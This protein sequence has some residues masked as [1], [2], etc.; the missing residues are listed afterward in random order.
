VS[1]GRYID[2]GVI[3]DVDLLPAQKVA[4]GGRYKSERNKPPNIAGFAASIQCQFANTFVVF[5]GLALRGRS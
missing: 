5:Q 2:S 3:L 4:A 1:P